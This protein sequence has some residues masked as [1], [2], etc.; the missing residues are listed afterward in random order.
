K[1]AHQS[2]FEYIKEKKRNP[3][4]D[5][6]I[7]STSEL[8]YG[9]SY[10]LRILEKLQDGLA[11]IKVTFENDTIS[12]DSKNVNRFEL[13][14]KGRRSDLPIQLNGNLLKTAAKGGMLDVL[15]ETR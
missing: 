5:S 8:K 10:G 2:A 3:K 9:E 13:D 12:I 15:I 7:V 6:I 1:D 14:L 11:T 4:P